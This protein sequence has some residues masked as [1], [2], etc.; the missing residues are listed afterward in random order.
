[1][2][3]EKE[4]LLFG[5][6]SK[7]TGAIA[8][9]TI[10]HLMLDATSLKPQ[11]TLQDYLQ[12]NMLFLNVIIGLLV[13]IVFLCLWYRRQRR[14]NESLLKA[15]EAK[16]VFFN[17]LSHEPGSGHHQCGADTGGHRAFCRQLGPAG[18]GDIEG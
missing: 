2:A 12:H 13:V 1:M 8:P 4:S 14:F 11:Y 7:N 15:T 17:N 9:S 16:N 10:H 18:S 3:E 5:I 6:L